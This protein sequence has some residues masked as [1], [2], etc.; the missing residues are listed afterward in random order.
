[1]STLPLKRG[2]RFQRWLPILG[3]ACVACQPSAPLVTPAPAKRAASHTSAGQ[4]AVVASRDTL[5]EQRLAR[6]ELRVLEK[7]AQLADVA[8]RLDEAR[9]EVVRAM[10]KL[11]T[12][13]SR[14]EAASAL[15]EAEIALQSLRAAAGQQ[16]GPDLVQATGLLQQG[17]AEFGKQNYAGALYLANQAKSVA[18]VAKN[19]A[20]DQVRGPLRPG[21][22]L[23]AV[24]IPLQAIA[25]GNIREGP[26]ASYPVLFTAEAG[27]ALVAYAAIEQWVRVADESGRGGWIHLTLVG[28]RQES[29][30]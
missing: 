28:K 30:R 8:L 14:A 7:D 1:M 17:T 3:V 27:A 15:A 4:G 18:G 12:L 11:Q 5:L 9:Q 20:G 26:G 29:G 2:R 19:R 21:E 24:P 22:T 13:A 16:A 23:F 6:L 25:R 10:A